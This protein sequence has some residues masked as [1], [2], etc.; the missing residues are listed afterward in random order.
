M[1][2]NDYI[3][4]DSRQPHL[5]LFCKYSI[6]TFDIEPK[7]RADALFFEIFLILAVTSC[8]PNLHEHS[9]TLWQLR[10]DLLRCQR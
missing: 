8:L 1:L 7:K 4:A 9:S 6:P 5:A 10:W 3:E 2:H